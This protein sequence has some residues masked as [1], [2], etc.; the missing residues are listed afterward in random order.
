MLRI[1]SQLPREE[2]II[3]KDISRPTFILSSSKVQN[4]VD[5]LGE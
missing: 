1:V 2:I 4:S 3:L 5:L